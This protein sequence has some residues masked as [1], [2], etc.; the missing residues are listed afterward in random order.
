M[1]EAA[2][3]G[4]VVIVGWAG[5]SVLRREPG[6]FS[7]FLHAPIEKRVRR[8]MKVYGNLTAEEAKALVLRS[9]RDRGEF[10]RTV[11]RTERLDPQNYHLCI[12]TE[13]FGTSAVVDLIYQAAQDVVRGL[14][15]PSEEPKG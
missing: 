3:R 15:G 1:R 9:N 6:L 4:P 10:A 11:L 5:F 13:R 7:V 8:V 12:D 14:G 2:E